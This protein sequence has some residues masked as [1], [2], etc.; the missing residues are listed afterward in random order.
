M[1]AGSSTMA[2]GVTARE[3][4]EEFSELGALRVISVNGPSVFEAICELGSFGV[5]DGWLHAITPDYHWHVRL[6]GVRH[7]TTRDQIHRRSGRRVLYFELREDRGAEPFLRVYLHRDKGEEL[8]ADRE[9]RFAALHALFV[10][11]QELRTLEV[12]P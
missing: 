12:D 5:A 11:G 10:N 3:L 9:A 8:T 1:S 2:P 6:A 4:F 7:L